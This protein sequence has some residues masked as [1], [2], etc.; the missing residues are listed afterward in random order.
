[1]SFLNNENKKNF[2]SPDKFRKVLH[3]QC[4]YLFRSRPSSRHQWR[5]L[6]VQG[7]R[8]QHRWGGGRVRTLADVVGERTSVGVWQ[9]W[10]HWFDVKVSTHKVHSRT[11]KFCRKDVKG[12]VLPWFHLVRSDPNEKRTTHSYVPFWFLVPIFPLVGLKH[13][14]KPEKTR[15]GKITI[16][17]VLQFLFFNLGIAYTVNRYGGRA[18]NLTQKIKDEFTT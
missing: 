4:H 12:F 15:L 14:T 6:T 3:I 18:V 5:P 16:R 11:R 17:T 13:S 1:M 2:F 8:F 9:F 10:V 7:L